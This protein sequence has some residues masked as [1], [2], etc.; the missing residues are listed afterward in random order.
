MTILFV[1]FAFVQLYLRVPLEIMLLFN[2]ASDQSYSFFPPVNFQFPL[3]STERKEHT[4][5]CT[6]SPFDKIQCMHG[7]G[8]CNELNESLVSGHKNI[9]TSKYFCV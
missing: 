7:N 6:K 3:L 4:K 8:A 5:K 2:K 1:N 9:N